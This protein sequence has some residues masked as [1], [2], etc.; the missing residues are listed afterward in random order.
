MENLSRMSSSCK[1][2]HPTNSKLL[3]S[4]TSH[5][6]CESVSK[7]APKYPKKI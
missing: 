4:Y 6:R 7:G 1:D 5:T 3:S 2:K